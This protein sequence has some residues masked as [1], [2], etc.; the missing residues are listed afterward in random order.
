VSTDRADY[1]FYATNTTPLHQLHIQCHELAHLLHGHCGTGALDIE[2][3]ALLMPSLP[4]S[5]IERVLGRTVYS[6]DE[7]QDAE[8][9][10]SLIMGRIGHIRP[11]RAPRSDMAAPLAQLAGVF[12]HQHHHG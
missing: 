5:V 4:S 10:A 7:E 12:D 1:I 9:L 6:T 8:L 3:A 2:V 11:L